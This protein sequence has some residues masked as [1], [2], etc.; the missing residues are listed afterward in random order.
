VKALAALACLACGIAL[1]QRPDCPPRDAP[2]PSKPPAH[3]IDVSRTALR[4]RDLQG[5]VPE[6]SPHHLTRLFRRADGTLRGLTE[7]RYRAAGGSVYRF[8]GTSSAQV[9]THPAILGGV[10]GPSG[11]VAS[12]LS[13]SDDRRHFK[14]EI[15]GVLEPAAQRATL[16][17]VAESIAEA[18][19][20]AE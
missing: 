14:L 17:S 7:L 13:W 12:T 16:L 2:P 1:A 20:E 6:T 15:A 4:G 8:E 10:K 18:A 19:R 3:A 11:C 9:G 5:T